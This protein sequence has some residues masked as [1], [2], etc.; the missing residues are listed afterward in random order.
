M[1]IKQKQNS[2]QSIISTTNLANQTKNNTILNYLPLENKTCTKE[3]LFHL[4]KNNYILK[5]K[6]KSAA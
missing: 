6:S 3:S 5:K 2:Q 4:R 1:T